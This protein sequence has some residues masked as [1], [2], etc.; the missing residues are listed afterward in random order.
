MRAHGYWRAPFGTVPIPNGM[1]S[2]A[3]FIALAIGLLLTM[4][5][6]LK[7]Q[8]I[9]VRSTEQP[10][11][12]IFASA[13]TTAS[14]PAATSDA[15]IGM[16]ALV[17]AQP[18][19]RVLMTNYCPV[20]EDVH[21]YRLDGSNP[22][23][24][25]PP[26]W[27]DPDFTPDS[28]WQRGSNVWWS[29]WDQA[30]WRPRN[31]GCGD[32]VG[33]RDPAGNPLGGSDQVYLCRYEFD[34]RPPE[35]GMEVR[36]A[37][38]QMWSDNQSQWWFDGR[39]L[40]SD[41]QGQPTDVALPGLTGTSGG[42][43]L[44]AARVDNDHTCLD[45]DYC[46]PHGLIFELTVV[47]AHPDDRQRASL[48][49]VARSCQPYQLIEEFNASQVFTAAPAEDPPGQINQTLS[50]AEFDGS[51]RRTRY[52]WRSLS[53]LAGRDLT[54][55]IAGMLST[56]NHNCG[57]AI[58][59][60][61]GSPQES[62]GLVNEQHIIDQRRPGVLIALAHDTRFGPAFD[63]IYAEWFYPDGS[64]DTTHHNQRWG[65][66]PGDTIPVRQGM[67]YVATLEIFSSQEKAVLTVHD[68]DGQLVGSITVNEADYSEPGFAESFGT[69]D[70]LLIGHALPWDDRPTELSQCTSWIDSVTVHSA[71][72][73]STN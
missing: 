3:P 63:H 6:L 34:L 46:N 55:T 40:Y 7:G 26:Q 36:R 51:K 25:I 21:I 47:W 58:A 37:T 64:H 28:V 61:K 5:S 68:G 17:P 18:S 44:V 9:W 72:C 2:T 13:V 50:R 14:E 41:Q 56:D 66:R 39:L 38:L 54:I 30:D 24:L 45:D 62:G 43:H 23:E 12:G 1:Q 57:V 42:K 69:L 60:R 67:W 35:V 15:P 49:T 11:A 8:S 19:P 48:P 22:G 52:L 59:L 20:A 73:T 70:T 33:L 10:K 27:N 31:V 29:A 71:G 32:P 53:G 65:I 16:S 4:P